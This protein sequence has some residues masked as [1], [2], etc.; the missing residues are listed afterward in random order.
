MRLDLERLPELNAESL[1]WAAF[2]YARTGIPVHPLKPGYK[3]PATRQGVHDA[4]TDL[5][6]VREHWRDHPDHNI[7][8]ATGHVFDVL[9]VDTKDGRPGT[10]SVERLRVAGLTVGVWAVASTPSGGRHI[11]FVPSGD[12]NHSNQASGLDFRGL[13]GYIVAPPSHTIETRKPSG[14][15]DQYEGTYQWEFAEPV[16]RDLPFDWAAAM[17]HICTG[18]HRDQSTG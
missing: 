9:D 8:I 4:S 5:R 7:G 10:E 1:G 2:F 16:A 11:L 13:G 3:V 17:E 12:G 14:Q 6:L 18:R 15:I